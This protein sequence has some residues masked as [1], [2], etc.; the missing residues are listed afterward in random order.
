MPINLKS[1]KFKAGSSVNDETHLEV[2]LGSILVLVGPNNSGKSL[3]LRE[4]EN[5]CLGTVPKTKVISNV[6]I[7]Y[8]DTYDEALQL[9]KHFEAG[10]PSEGQ[11]KDPSVCGIL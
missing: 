6:G 2:Q 4:I 8:P 5:W 11:A 3:A 7:R 9:L 1:I 10:P